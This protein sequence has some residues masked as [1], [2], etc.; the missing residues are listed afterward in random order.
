[1]SQYRGR[2]YYRNKRIQLL[3]DMINDLIT[4][5]TLSTTK[6]ERISLDNLKNLKIDIENMLK[7]VGYH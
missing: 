6:I 7:E 5:L 4:V 2:T 1:M 3:R